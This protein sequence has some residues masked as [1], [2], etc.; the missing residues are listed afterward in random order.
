MTTTA[1]ESAL[2]VRPAGAS[3]WARAR[4][5]RAA[6][7]TPST[8]IEVTSEATASCGMVTTVARGNEAHADGR[9]PVAGLAGLAEPRVVAA[10]RSRPVTSGASTT[11][12]STP[13]PSARRRCR[14]RTAA[15]AGRPAR[16]ATPPRGPLGTGKSATS[17]DV[18]ARRARRLGS[19]ADAVAV[20][21][22]GG[23]PRV[24]RR[25][26]VRGGRHQPTAPSIC[27]SMRRFSSRAY[28]MGSSRA[29]GS[30]NPRTIMAMASV[31]VMPRDMR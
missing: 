5:V 7:S 14:R 13:W 3:R 10:R 24:V 9:G 15:R 4:L 17:N 29:M 2:G 25:Q 23:G 20:A 12:V 31:S 30:T 11:V 8:R 18:G 6:P 22:V 21:P 16:S 1:C 19:G 27:S 28:S 26:G